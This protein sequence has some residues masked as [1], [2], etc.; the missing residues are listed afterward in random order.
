[1][2]AGRKLQAKLVQSFHLLPALRLVW[3]SSPRWTVA[4]GFVLILQ[5]ILP[6]ISLFLL[7]LIIDQIAVS[8]SAVDKN[9]AFH[10]ALILLIMLGCVML[11]NSAFS[12]L[13]ELVSAAQAQR[14]TDYMQELL[15]RKSVAVDLEY[16]ENSQYYDTLQ[17]AQQEAPFRPNQILNRIA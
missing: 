13:S 11:L 14:V 8:L 10:Q 6:L 3:Q 1:M 4:R 15:F 7:K 2:S 5:G 16:Y 17:R 12:S 9:A